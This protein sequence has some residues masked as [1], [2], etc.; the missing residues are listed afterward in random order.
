MKHND[1]H[2]LLTRKPDGDD[3][4]RARPRR[5]PN[6]PSPRHCQASPPGGP[7]PVCNPLSI[8]KEGN[9][10]ALTLCASGLEKGSP[11][12]SRLNS[13]LLTQGESRAVHSFFLS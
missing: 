11:D 7:A 3:C 8:S 10:G 6:P 12:G 2:R 1:L 13:W 5:P 4:L 9:R